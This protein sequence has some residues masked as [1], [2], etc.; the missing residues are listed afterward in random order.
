MTIP[1]HFYPDWFGAALD[2]AREHAGELAVERDR[3]RQKV[4]L[5]L[6][7]EALGKQDLDTVEQAINKMMI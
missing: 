3:V 7:L 4:L 1:I 2:D 5:H 6:A